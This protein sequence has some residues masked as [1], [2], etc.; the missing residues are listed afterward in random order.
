MIPT[1]VKIDGID[2]MVLYARADSIEAVVDDP[3]RPGCVLVQVNGN[4]LGGNGNATD[5]LIDVMTAL[6]DGSPADH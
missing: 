3:R 4:L 2:G 5:V 1:F 6:A